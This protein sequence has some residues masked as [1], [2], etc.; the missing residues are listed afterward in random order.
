MEHMKV[1]LQP[2]FKGIDKGDGGI[3]RVVE[4]QLKHLP[5]FGIEFVDS[6]ESADLVATHAT[7]HP[8]V[9]VGLPW[10]THNHGLYYSDFGWEGAWYDRANQ[11]LVEVLR[12]ADHVTAPSEWVAQTMRRGMWLRPTVLHHG[13][14]FDEWQ[15]GRNDGYV[16]WNKTRV[17][18]SC[19]PSIVDALAQKALGLQFISTF[20]TETPNVQ[21]TG[22]LP[23]Q[24][25]RDYVKNAGVYLCTARETFGIGTI[26]AMAAGVPVVGWAWGGQREIISHKETGWLVR[27]GDIDG[28]I[29]GIHWALDNHNAVG[30]RAKEDV[31]ERF[32][33]PIAMQRYADLYQGMITQQ[34]SCAV[35][36]IVPCYNLA[37]YL[38]DTLE[39]VRKQTM[40]SW[41]CIIVDDASTDNSAEIAKTFVDKD[42]RFR[43]LRNEK[44]SKVSY[45]RNRGLAEAQ[46]HYVACLDADDMLT[47]NALKILSTALD[48]D[49]GIHLAYGGLQIMTEAG[50]VRTNIHDWPPQFDFVQQIQMHNQVPTFCMMRRSVIE[51]TG[52]YR[53]R[54]NPVEDAD[55]W[56]RVASI[57]LVPKKVTEA[58]VLL[59][60][61]RGDSLS[62][63]LKHKDWGHWY[64]WSLKKALTPWAAPVDPPKGTLA[65]PIPTFEPAKV[66][67]IIPVGPGH[68]EL[69]IDALDSVEAQT[70]RQWECVVVNDTG[71]PLA[72]PHSW[73]KVIDTDGKTGVAHARNLGIG[74]STAPFIVPLDADDYLQPDALAMMLA[75]QQEAGGYVYS[76]WIEDFGAETKVYQPKDYDPKLLLAQGCLHAVTALYAKSDI[77]L[78]GGF[79]E[80]LSHWEDWDLQLGLA[81]H[82]V[83]GTK[84]NQPLFT[85]RKNTG[86]RREDNVASFETGKEVILSKWKTYWEGKEELMACKACPAGR[87]RTPDNGASLLAKSNG[88]SAV[89]LEFTG[90]SPSVRSFRSVVQGVQPYRFGNEP[91]HKVKYVTVPDAEHLLSLAGQFRRVLSPMPEQTGTIIEAVLPMANEPHADHGHGALT[92]K[93]LRDLLPTL[94]VEDARVMIAKE[95]ADRNRA[96]VIKLLEAHAAAAV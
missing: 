79:D 53:I 54:N 68:E 39:S 91:H 57:G 29:E 78:V 8:N 50:E 33:W 58:P 45:T 3:R 25:A 13:V 20:G 75:V 7:T 88:E 60:R 1:F 76:A 67:V 41:E 71:K 10:V 73:A 59:Y 56:T 31:L 94:S 51:R 48:K 72:I 28:L 24:V 81:K 17:D 80:S 44:N 35:S 74:A 38:G 26:E 16:L 9:P 12:Q 11:E 19:D 40:E 27:P 14:D 69:L 18:A 43:Y 2:I 30:Q 32:T 42:K 52:G 77:L 21:I 87:V 65:W 5:D 36:I 85:Y 22:A 34:F 70:Y 82:G 93:E 84:I 47:P 66:A 83:C 96:N 64:P 61:L 6:M 92:F 46:G 37:N 15:G 63:T 49:R 55:L 62:R 86:Y 23:Y 4:A 95:R 90:Q 89:L